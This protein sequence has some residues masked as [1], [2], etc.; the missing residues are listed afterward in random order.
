MHQL[1]IFDID[2]TL[3]DTNGVDDEAYRAAVA[4]AIDV[5]PELIDWSGALHVT[6]AEIFR[7]LCSVH[8]RGEPAV[9]LM[10]E[11]RSQ[12]VARLTSTLTE[13][14]QRFVEIPG[15]GAMLRRLTDEGWCVALATGGWGASARLKLRAACLVV[16]DA[17]IACADDGQ[18]RA[19]IVEIAR[20]RAESLYEKRF[21]RVVSVGD[22]VWDVE[23]AAALDLPFIGIARGAKKMRLRRAGADVVFAD[24]RDVEEFLKALETAAAPRVG[25]SRGESS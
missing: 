2:G 8:G 19:D 9:E 3:T 15:A 13:A 17:L 10:A 24:Y 16:D 25:A 7:H 21:D 1:A 18:S 20:R 23:T 5:A 11:A 6:D 22:G 12:F 14:P 4:A